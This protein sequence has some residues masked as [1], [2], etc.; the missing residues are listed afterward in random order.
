MHWIRQS[1]DCCLWFDLAR[2]LVCSQGESQEEKKENGLEH[3]MK[4]LYMPDMKDSNTSWFVECVKCIS[5]RMEI[6]CNLSFCI[7]KKEIGFP[8][9]LQTYFLSSKVLL[10]WYQVS[11][12]DDNIWPSFTLSG[13]Q[14]VVYT[15][16]T[17]A[18]F[19]HNYLYSGSL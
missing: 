10:Y 1:W 6:P 4:Y 15:L 7:L 8:S 3:E 16:H 17:C 19:R 9:M 18:S 5:V 12:C 2:K 11:E 13:I 14:W